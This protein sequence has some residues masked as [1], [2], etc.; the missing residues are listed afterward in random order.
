MEFHR[1]VR[2]KLTL[3]CDAP[4]C[5]HSESIPASATA[6]ERAS[7]IGKPCPLCGACL[8]TAEDHAAYESAMAAIETNNKVFDTLNALGLLTGNAKV[9][10]PFTINPRA[11]G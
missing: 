4:G 2:T 5:T 7:Y 11:K 8:L 3:Q 10:K 6:A 9:G 1:L